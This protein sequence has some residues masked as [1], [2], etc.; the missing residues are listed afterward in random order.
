MRALAIAMVVILAVPAV[1]RADDARA[2]LRLETRAAHAGVPFVIDMVIE[3][4][5][6]SPAPELPALEIAGARVTPLAVAPPQLSHSISIVNGR[7]TESSSATWVLRWRVQTD[8]DGT[9]HVPSLKATQGSKV[10]VAPAGDVPVDTIP[11]S[12]DMKVSLDLPDRPMFLGET[13][14]VTLTWLF[15]REPQD[16]PQFTVP[17]LGLDEVS[18]SVTPP[19]G[20]Q[21][22]ME[23]EA[24]G[25]K[26]EL[27]YNVDQTTVDG[28]KYNRVQLPFFISPRKAGKIEL[29]ATSVVA[30]LAV[31]RQDFFGNS[32]SRMFRASDAGRTLEVLPLPEQ[33]KPA[34]FAGAVGTQFSI[35]VATS[36]SVVS[37][38]E[39]VEMSIV[40]KSNQSLD[41]LALPP[42][43][44]PK[45]KFTVPQE[46]PTGE[47]SD[48]G[49][50]KTF[51]VTAEVVG[52]TSEIPAV[53][54]SY[55][56][57]KARTYQTIHS[58]PIALS[59]KGG[60]LVGTN[61]V[62]GVTKTP[63][64]VGK[65]ESEVSLVGADLA[66]SSPGNVDATPLGGAV[67]WVLVALLHL[68]PIAILVLRSWQ[69]RTASGREDAAELKVAKRRLDA[70]LAAAAAKP[71]RDTSGE[72][73]AAVRN[74]ARV[75]ERPVD[76]K[77]LLGRIE[78]ESFAPAAANAPLSRSLLDE[79]RSLTSGWATVVFA[80]VFF[81][82]VA[83]GT[84]RADALA[85]GRAQ[86]QDAM[87]SSDASAKRASFTRAE[88]SLGEAVRAMP[89]RPE[90]LADWGNAALGA[91]DLGTATL[92]YRRALVLDGENPRARRNLDWLR[93][94]QTDLF[95]PASGG[96]TES[97]FFFHT[98]SR[99]R[100]IIVAGSAFALAVLLLVPWRGRRRAWQ[101][102]VSL[103]PFAVWLAMLLSVGV[104]D[105]HED[106][107]VVMDAVVLRA[108]DSPGA[109][110]AMN[111]QVPRGA[112]VVIEERREAWTKVR[113]ANGTT[114]WVPEG[115]VRR[116][117]E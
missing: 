64:K 27:A 114:G 100:R 109:P 98:W 87:Q 17:L 33:G 80:V 40:V 112:E 38:G 74:L 90:L 96:A 32:P 31:G 77:G 41:S 86:Y 103:I 69:L 72:L 44:L 107:A 4:F 55:F 54:F 2:G 58:D 52:A 1:A 76:D 111:A 48:D 63:S 75:M 24:G 10:A 92:A 9:L 81:G 51:K 23:I 79:V 7:R 115:T 3:G 25:K 66:L 88:A 108:A 60:G 5:D 47:L 67:V 26:L 91:G 21:R 39:P 35:S 13:A 78:T 59:V 34:S 11:V 37:R 94:R 6:E 42:L 95:R 8:K 14:K 101:V 117:V 106:D 102:P 62:V 113:I 56:D 93:S 12:D 22:T 70:A 73:G 46:A 20:Q 30:S 82:V 61:D 65:Q 19:D 57:P 28:Q 84:A 43:D 105:R 53:A 89:D 45:D 99:A 16:R 85:D 49:K 18:V 104:E 110:A 36:R 68:I 15:R 83:A 29:P 50:T 116:V 71:A 97:L